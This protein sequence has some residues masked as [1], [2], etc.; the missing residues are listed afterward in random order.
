M[1]TRGLGTPTASQYNVFDWEQLTNFACAPDAGG[2]RTSDLFDLWISNPTLYQLR[3]PPPHNHAAA[4]S[5]VVLSDA[6]VTEPLLWSATYSES[7]VSVGNSKPA[8]VGEDMTPVASCPTLVL[9]GHTRRRCRCCRA[10]QDVAVGAAGPHKTSL[11]VLLHELRTNTW[12]ARR[13]SCSL[14][15]PPHSC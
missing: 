10:T 2:V 9:P 11:S 8:L 3:Y 5:P 7:A 4:T 14:K 12:T 15:T 6:A 1:Y 13:Q